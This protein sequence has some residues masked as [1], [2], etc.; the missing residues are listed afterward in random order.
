MEVRTDRAT[1]LFDNAMEKHLEH[2]QGLQETIGARLFKLGEMTVIEEFGTV[3]QAKAGNLVDTLKY[4][5]G[6]IIDS[7]G[8]RYIVMENGEWRK[9]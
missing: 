4:A 7:G 9:I 6:E 1:F 2:A 8:R 5:T 3:V